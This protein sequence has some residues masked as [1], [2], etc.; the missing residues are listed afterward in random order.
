MFRLVATSRTEP[1]RR[2]IFPLK[3]KLSF[4]IP[5]PP[6]TLAEAIRLRDEFRNWNEFWD[7]ELFDSE[8]REQSI[9][10][11]EAIGLE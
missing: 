9:F 8:G 10:D 5:G 2:E 6:K 7:F 3:D 11:W 4:G 1:T